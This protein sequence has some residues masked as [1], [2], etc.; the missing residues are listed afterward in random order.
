MFRN[1]QVLSAPPTLPQ[2]LHSGSG[3]CPKVGFSSK[4]ARCGLGN[5]IGTGAMHRLYTEVDD[6]DLITSRLGYAADIN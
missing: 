2:D 1:S 4:T 6:G 3:L 5:Q